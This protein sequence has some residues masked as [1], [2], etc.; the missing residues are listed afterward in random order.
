MG[1]K[2]AAARQAFAQPLVLVTWLTA[3]SLLYPMVPGCDHDPRTRVL[4]VTM[5]QYRMSFSVVL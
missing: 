3:I 1:F 5:V 2:G 4:S